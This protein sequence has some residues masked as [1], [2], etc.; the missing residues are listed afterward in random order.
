MK[1]FRKDSP[2][3]EASI[4]PKILLETLEELDGDSLILAPGEV[5]VFATEG[6]ERLG[7]LRDGKIQSPELMAT[8]RVVRRTHSKQVGQI[9]PKPQNPSN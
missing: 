9:T 7:V 3:L 6:I 8:V 1:L 2:G 5:P 4:L